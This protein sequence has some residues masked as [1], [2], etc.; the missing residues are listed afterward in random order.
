MPEPLSPTIGFGMKVAVFPYACAVLCTAYFRRLQPVGAL[1]ERREFGA[2]LV[3]SGGGD[4]VMVDF[5]LDAHLLEREADRGADVLQR[6]DRRD[7]EI[8]A[9]DRG[10]VPHVAAFELLG[11]RPRRFTRKYLAVAARHVDRPLDGVEDEELGLRAEIRDV[12][13][14]GRLEIGLCALGE[15][16]R[17]A[18]VALAV[19]WAR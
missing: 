10:P 17:I 15:R 16:A 13:H 1:D 19:R 12:A 5:D 2:D 8:A 11:R 4:L 6:V 7:R 3:L 18:F 14:A 9:L